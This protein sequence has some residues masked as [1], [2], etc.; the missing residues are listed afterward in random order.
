MST[1]YKFYFSSTEFFIDKN[2]SLVRESVC[3]AC[4]GTKYEIPEVWQGFYKMAAN[5][6]DPS[7]LEDEEIKNIEK[8]YWENLGHTVGEFSD[9][10]KQK[11]PCSS[12][13][14]TGTLKEKVRLLKVFNFLFEMIKSWESNY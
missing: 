2:I 1:D 12:C 3:P 5:E 11:V 13:S 7:I 14:G 10:P 4:E 9:R 6:I 8:A